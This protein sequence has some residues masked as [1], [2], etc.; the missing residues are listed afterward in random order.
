M[1]ETCSSV[2]LLPSEDGRRNNSVRRFASLEINELGIS[3]GLLL[4]LQKLGEVDAGDSSETA[5]TADACWRLIRTISST[6]PS[7]MVKQI[8]PPIIHADASVPTSIP[9]HRQSEKTNVY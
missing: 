9:G 5:S 3:H 8:V 6:E 7:P 1:V 4:P 2:Y